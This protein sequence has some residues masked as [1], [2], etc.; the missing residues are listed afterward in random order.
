MGLGGMDVGSKNILPL[1]RRTNEKMRSMAEYYIL[2]KTKMSS[3]FLECSIKNGKD[4]SWEDQNPGPDTT[5]SCKHSGISLNGEEDHSCW[6]VVIRAGCRDVEWGQWLGIHRQ[7]CG[8]QE[9]PFFIIYVQLEFLLLSSQWS[10]RHAFVWWSMVI[11]NWIVLPH[12]QG[13]L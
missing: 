10:T 12:L 11:V 3:V 9:F 1:D 8:G 6:A 4:E 7:S 5:P 2:L 13:C